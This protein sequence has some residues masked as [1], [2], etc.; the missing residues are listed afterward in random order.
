MIPMGSNQTDVF[1]HRLFV[2]ELGDSLLVVPK[3]SLAHGSHVSAETDYS[4][5]THYIKACCDFLRCPKQDP[6]VGIL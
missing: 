6:A 5:I 3:A 2:L 4:L 1:E